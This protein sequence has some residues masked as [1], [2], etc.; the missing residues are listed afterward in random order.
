MK[1]IKI[2]SL[3]LAV[4]MLMGTVALFAS[5]G[6]EAGVITPSEDTVE[7]DLSD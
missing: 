1:R 4:L 3:V 6:T 5:C 2:L 7:V